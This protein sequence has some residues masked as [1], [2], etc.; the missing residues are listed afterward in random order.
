MRETKERFALAL[1]DAAQAIEE[2]A[3]FLGD[4]KGTARAFAAG[5]RAR[6]L[7]SVDAGVGEDD[8]ERR[9]RDRF[10]RRRLGGV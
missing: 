4:V 8:R 5:S 1:V 3:C 6:E 9:E 7:R 2:R 10:D